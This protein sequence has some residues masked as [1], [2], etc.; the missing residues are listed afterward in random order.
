VATTAIAIPTAA[1]MLP[2]RAVRGWF[3]SRRPMMKHAKAAM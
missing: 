3:R 2:F 1:I